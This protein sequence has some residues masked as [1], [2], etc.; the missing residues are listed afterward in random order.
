[1]FRKRLP[2]V[3]LVCALCLLS[4]TGCGNMKQER[5]LLAQ[6]QALIEER[7]YPQAIGLLSEIADNKDAEKLLEQ[8]YYVISGDYIEN[9]GVGAAAIDREEHVRFM[10]HPVYFENLYAGQEET[11]KTVGE[12]KNIRRL[13]DGELGLDALD[14]DGGFYTVR[15]A[16]GYDDYTERNRQIAELEPLKMLC[17]YIYDFT[18]LRMDGTIC[19]YAKYSDYLEPD[20]VKQHMA[21]W[22]DIKDI[23]SG[24]DMVAVLL[25]DGTVDF[26]CADYTSSYDDILE[27]TDIVA[28]DGLGVVGCIA[29]LKSDGTVVVSNH[30]V[31]QNGVIYT[32]AFE[33]SD[34][35]AISKGFE[36]LLGLKRDGTVVAAGNLRSGQENIAEWTDIVAISAGQDIHV[37]LKRDGSIVIA[38]DFGGILELP[39]M[40]SM[41]DLY[42]P[43]VSVDNIDES[44]AAQP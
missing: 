8:L 42:V 12:W 13:S 17:S 22:T 14:K 41:K 35:I 19:A 30:G 7:K 10:A 11:L 9:L 38:G 43:D 40:T 2:T 4:G 36:S 28:I 21:R 6:A 31:D 15:G 20:P 39:D 34:I 27:W 25:G 3:L 26:V 16:S 32:D 1:M 5:E 33:W 37:G 18:V 24:P 44:V 23:V 29:G